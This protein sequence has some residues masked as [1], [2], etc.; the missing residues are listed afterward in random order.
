M[1]GESCTRLAVN[2]KA[3]LGYA[4]Q[5]GMERGADGKNGQGLGFKTRGVRRGE[6]SSEV[7]DGQLGAR[8]RLAFCLCVRGGV[9]WGTGSKNTWA[10]EAGPPGTG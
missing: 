2:Q 4:R 8:V 1:A 10:M 9:A 3:Y 7:D 5:V 6:G